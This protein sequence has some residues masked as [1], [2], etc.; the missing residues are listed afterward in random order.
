MAGLCKLAHGVSFHR[1]VGPRHLY[2]SRGHGR[3]DQSEKERVTLLAV[4]LDIGHEGLLV[5]A[6]GQGVNKVKEKSEDE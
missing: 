4:G 3:H 1:H 5:D 2:K 6:G